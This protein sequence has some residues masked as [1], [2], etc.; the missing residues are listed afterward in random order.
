MDSVRRPSFHIGRVRA[1]GA[2]LWNPSVECYP[3]E[4]V[5][6]LQGPQRRHRC[7]EAGEGCGGYAR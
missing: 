2:T 6:S 7:T 5:N 4:S 3:P 1:S